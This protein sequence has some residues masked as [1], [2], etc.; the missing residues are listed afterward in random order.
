MLGAGSKGSA[1]PATTNMSLP[2]IIG[3]LRNGL[4]CVIDLKPY[5]NPVFPFLF[6]IYPLRDF[7]PL[8]PNVFASPV[9]KDVVNGL[10]AVDLLDFIKAILQL[11][12]FFQLS[13]AG[14]TL[15]Y[16]SVQK[17][18]SVSS[19]GSALAAKVKQSKGSA[20]SAGSL[21][22]SSSS[23]SAS[24]AADV[25]PARRS[26]RKVRSKAD[27]DEPVTATNPKEQDASTF[28]ASSLSFLSASLSAFQR[29]LLVRKIP[30]ALCLLTLGVSFFWLF[31]NSL[32]LNEL[33]HPDLKTPLPY[34][35]G[36]VNVIHSLT[37][38]ELALVPLLY[39]MVVD[40]LDALSSKSSMSALLDRIEDDGNDENCALHAGPASQPSK[41]AFDLIAAAADLATCDGAADIYAAGDA[42]FA[43][44]FTAETI[45]KNM[46][47]YPWN[48]DCVP[49]GA[50]M[51]GRV[52]GCVDNI[53]QGLSSMITDKRRPII[54]REAV[55]ILL[56][57]IK[58]L[59]YEVWRSALILVFNVFAFH[60]YLLGILVYH[61]SKGNVPAHAGRALHLLKFGLDHGRADWWGNFIGDLCWT[62]EPALILFGGTIIVAIDSMRSKKEKKGAAKKAAQ[63]ATPKKAAQTPKKAAQTPKAKKE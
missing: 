32:H 1:P 43:K 48:C 9:V 28:T 46:A 39:L 51:A 20:S 24:S 18:A 25:D 16:D 17:L 6:S 35:G 3:L 21:A 33:T 44:N 36:F 54:V 19:W 14:I 53:N 49:A 55:P 8:S 47:F 61:D 5:L 38:M 58:R 26:A 23:S 56:G 12:A 52:D 50:D 22:S 13:Y 41:V 15:L 42:A 31:A 40:V 45:E 2:T 34:V 4:C 10:L 60:G 57:G 30:T 7:T 62:L 63:P 27:K 11:Y 59:D 37:A 29:D